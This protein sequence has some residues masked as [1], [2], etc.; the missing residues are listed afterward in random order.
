MDLKACFSKL[1]RGMAAQIAK[2]MKISPS[3]LSQMVSG[4]APISPA[5][6]VEF[7]QLLKGEVTRQDIYPDDWHLIWPELVTPDSRIP[8][9][10]AA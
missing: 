9:K 3:Y 6:A 2:D 1:E 5:R 10:K 7:E 8:T 4:V